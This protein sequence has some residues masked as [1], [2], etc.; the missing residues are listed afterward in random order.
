MKQEKLAAV[1]ATQAKPLPIVE[2]LGIRQTPKGKVVFSVKL[3][4]DKVISIEDISAP[5]ETL[6]AE[7]WLKVELAKRVLR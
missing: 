7:R 1:P 6:I 2:A 5:G 3:Q 4:G